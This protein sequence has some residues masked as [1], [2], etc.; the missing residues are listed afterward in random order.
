MFY[1]RVKLTGLLTEAPALLGLIFTTHKNKV[2]ISSFQIRSITL[3][4]ELNLTFLTL[5]NKRH[6][7]SVFHHR[8]LNTVKTHNKISNT[9]VW[10]M[11][12]ENKMFCFKDSLY[13]NDPL[14]R[15]VHI[16]TSWD[17]DDAQ[18]KGHMTSYWNIDFWPCAKP[19]L[20]LVFVF[21]FKKRPLHAST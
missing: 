10:S 3:T 18:Q 6:D 17:Q 16:L 20:L 1:A 4:D 12:G 19:P 9:S 11:I 7:C 5:L 14:H 8:L 21:S 15:A 13:W 2:R